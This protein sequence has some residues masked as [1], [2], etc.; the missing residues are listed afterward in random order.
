MTYLFFSS[1]GK[2]GVQIRTRTGPSC[3]QMHEW[4][5]GKLLCAV[6][7][8]CRLLVLKLVEAGPKRYSLGDFQRQCLGQIEAV[9]WWRVNQGAD[10]RFQL[11]NFCYLCV[12]IICDV[13]VPFSFCWPQHILDPHVWHCWMHHVHSDSS[14]SLCGT[15]PSDRT[16][17]QPPQARCLFSA[18]VSAATSNA[19]RTWHV[20]Q[21][22]HLSIELASQW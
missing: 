22:K 9:K 19:D 14:S 5:I 1:G 10:H 13:T 21:R 11:A 15:S 12:N 17:L 6:L 2:L 18:R 7:S 3:S 8:V 20:A 4:I 16:S